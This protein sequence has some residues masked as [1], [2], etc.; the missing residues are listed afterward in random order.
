MLLYFC[1]T[2]LNNYNTAVLPDK[3]LICSSIVVTPGTIRQVT[4][5]GEWMFAHLH[6]SKP[7]TRKQLMGFTWVFIPV[8]LFTKSIES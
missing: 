7:F 3:T 1:I 8:N 6:M 5:F 2:V 4:R